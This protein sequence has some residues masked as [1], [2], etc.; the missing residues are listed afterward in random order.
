MY[1]SIQYLLA[2]LPVVTTRS[3][4]GR[5]VFF[6]QEY[7]AT[8]DDRAEAVRLGVEEL[9]RRDIPPGV[10]RAKTLARIA[11]QRSA[12][13][14]IVQRIYDE[15][16]EGR[17]FSAEWPALFHHKMLRHQRHEDTIRLLE[18][19]TTVRNNASA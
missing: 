13:I 19:S 18:D 4:G 6:D 7:V 10:I 12:L 11:V 1:A 8:V 9:I 17:D 2:G 5:D 14:A 3:L 15:E 16:G